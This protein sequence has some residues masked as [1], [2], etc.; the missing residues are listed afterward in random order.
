M[1]LFHRARAPL[2]LSLLA[3]AVV[4]APATSGA[5]RAPGGSDLATGA[6][7]A[8][9]LSVGTAA[10]AAP[11]VVLFVVDDATVEDITY[12]PKVQDRLIVRGTTFTRHYVPYPLCCPSRATIFTGLYPHNHRVLGNFDP[13][14]GFYG[15]KDTQTIATWLTDDY[16]TS[17]VG[18]YFND[19]ADTNA[20]RRY[21]PP[22]WDAWKG[23]VEPGT[24]NY[25]RQKLNL[26]GRLVDFP[27]VYSTSLFGQQ[28]RLFLEHQGSKEPFFL[29]ESFVAPHNGGPRDPDDVYAGSP[30]VQPK[31]R[32]TYSGP[33]VPADSSYNEA[34]VSDKESGV[35]NLPR[36]S[37]DKIAAQKESLVQRREAL[38]TVDDEIG[39]TM[40]MIRRMGELQNTYFM[41]VSDN[42]YL[43][44]QHRI[45]AGKR[46]AY[47]P[48]VR[49][50]LIIRGPGIQ[51]GGTY[52]GLTGMQDL[53]PTILSMTDEWD[54]TIPPLD[55]RSLLPLLDGETTDRP[56]VL[57]VADAPTVSEQRVATSTDESR[58]VER[59]DR[60]ALTGTA[61][62]QIEWL[63]R[64][65]VTPDRWKYVTYPQTGGVEMYDLTADPYELE[66][67]AGNPDYA[68]KQAALDAEW[69]QYRYCDAVQCW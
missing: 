34:D 56:I 55:G 44:G 31:Y 9:G 6:A 35:E 41:L 10:A 42:G 17:L 19:Y 7:V 69:R 20:D 27:G 38:R 64:G 32:D 62:L 53:A 25:L 54:A 51:V 57:E 59:D 5:T 65:I 36:L 40:D 67:L 23:S 52:D 61:S 16:A 60:A 22:G 3:V 11:N 2:A 21:V 58:F 24:Y 33:L 30:Y 66:N 37:R 18:K 47:E 14:G 8:P 49:V 45:A 28:G 29:Y 68:D 39:R 4:A 48:A 50:P 13:Y 26:N 12:M 43:Q 15:F 46:V 1:A 63:A